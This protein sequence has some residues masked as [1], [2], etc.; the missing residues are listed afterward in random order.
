MVPVTTWIG[1]DRINFQLQSCGNNSSRF[2]G[3]GGRRVSADAESSIVAN[4]RSMSTIVC[5]LLSNKGR[6]NPK[7]RPKPTLNSI[8]IGIFSTSQ[9]P[10]NPSNNYQGMYN[11]VRNMHRNGSAELKLF[12]S[13]FSTRNCCERSKSL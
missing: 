12:L 3:I 10:S 9:I 8:N 13:Y 7:Q 1:S 11:I 6:E 5:S 2:Y 4:G